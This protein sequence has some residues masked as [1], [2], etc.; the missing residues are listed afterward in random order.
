[1]TG[2]KRVCGVSVLVLGVLLSG[3]ITAT[4]GWRPFIGPKSRPLTD[5]RFESTPARLE[6][7]KY[8]VT[9][10]VP[11]QLCHSEL[12]T[13]P[14]GLHIPEGMAFAGRNW[15]PE[16]VAFVT[17]PNL[18]PDPETGIG[19]LSDD[20]L[21][22]A[23]REGISH[24]GRALFPIMPYQAF[25]AMTDEDL[26]SIIVYLR[27][28]KPVRHRMP[29][30]DV[31]FPVKHLIKG[32]PEPVEGSVTADLSTQEKRGEYIVRMAGC[33]DCH[34]PMNDQGVRVPGMDFSG[35]NTAKFEGLAPVAVAN[36]TPGVNGIP[37]YTE[38]LFLEVM[39]TGRVRERQLHPMMPTKF[40]GNMTDDDLKATF[41]YLKTLKPVDH[42]IDNTM[43]P[44]KCAKCGL[45]HG[46][47]ERNK[48]N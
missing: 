9:A 48:K 23:I 41:A 14:D 5:R 36:I 31:P 16:G 24:D 35:G 6:R 27:T 44:T 47:G 38:D 46:G 19:N 26:A 37:Y 7:G 18:T 2:W 10:R 29:P 11:C 43:P 45:E 20:A 34:T 12:K 15:A 32:L 40:Y 33:A 25:Q 1:M 17:A 39:R 4:I 8:L 30:T 21:A 13:G 42:F 28:L 3:G 22:R